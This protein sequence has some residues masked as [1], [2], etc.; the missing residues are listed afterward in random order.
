MSSRPSVSTKRPVWLFGL[1]LV[2]LALTAATEQSRSKRQAWHHMQNDVIPPQPIPVQPM[3]MMPSVNHLCQEPSGTVGKRA[4]QSLDSFPNLSQ[5]FMNEDSSDV[6]L[7]V[8]GTK[9]PAHR[10]VLGAKSPKFNE[11]FRSD[12]TKAEFDL[13]LESEDNFKVMLK[14]FYTE[15]FQMGDDKDYGRAIEI[16]K[17]AQEYGVEGLKQQVERSLAS[18]I[19]NDNYIEVL[20]FIEDNQMFELGRLWGNF[21]YSNSQQ[22]MTEAKFFN[23]SNG[24]VTKVLQSLNAPAS[25][26]ISHIR[27]LMEDDPSLSPDDLRLLVHLDRCTVDDLIVLAQ[28]GLYDHKF[29]FEDMIK[30]YK[31]L[32][33]SC[34]RPIQVRRAQPLQPRWLPNTGM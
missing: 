32:T 1:V 26:V 20:K 14:Y 10:F 11:L 25:Y 18:W 21:V 33:A 17:M 22:I 19:N 24:V 13:G 28:M 30:R 12:P 29:L 15:Q 7:V 9:Y 23:E 3:V 4:V 2:L 27:K 6:K 31:A 34:M 16:F 8:N 5:Y